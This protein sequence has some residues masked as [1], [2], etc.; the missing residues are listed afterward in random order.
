MPGRGRGILWKSN[1]KEA[2]MVVIREKFCYSKRGRRKGRGNEQYKDTMASWLC[3]GNGFGASGQYVDERKAEDITVTMIRDT[4]PDG[5]FRYFEDHHIKTVN[6]Y[7]GIYY[8]LDTVLFPT[9]IV[10]GRELE[11]ENHVWLKALSDRINRQQ[12]EE[13]LEKAN[14][15]KQ[16]FERELADSVLEISIKANRWVAEEVRGDDSMGQAIV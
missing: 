10:V 4:K 9:Q 8:V 5:L 13:L 6:P 14:S 1:K 11:Q 2:G 3:S 16:K 7:R 15:L 12:M